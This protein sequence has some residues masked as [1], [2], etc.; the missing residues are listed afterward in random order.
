MKATIVVASGLA[1]MLAACMAVAQ[2]PVLGN[3][4]SPYPALQS[5]VQ[6][7]GNVYG[8]GVVTY[9]SANTPLVLSGSNLGSSGIVEFVSYHNEGGGEIVGSAI[10]ATIS[11]WSSNMIF[12]T[13]PNGATSGLVKVLVEGKTSNG[14]PF[15]V[16]PGSYSASCPSFPPSAQLQIT[17]SALHSGTVGQPYSATLS[18]SGGSGA[19]N[20]TIVS[21][22]LPNGLALNSGTGTISGTPTG[23]AGPTDLQVQVTDGESPAQTNVA[24][25][26]LTIQSQILNQGSIYNYSAFYDGVGNV[27]SL[28]DSVIGNW[29]FT[30]DSL[31]RIASGSV[32]L[33]D[34]SGRY[35]YMCWSYDAFGN[36]TQQEM[37]SLGF[38][39]GSGGG[40]AC[41][42][43]STAPVATDIASYDGNNRVSGTNAHG[44]TATPS[45]DSA[46]N[47]L[48]DGAESYL[49]D[50]EGRVCA[51][52]GAPIFGETVMTGYIYDAEGRRVAKGSIQSMSCDPSSNGFSLTESYVLSGNGDELTM[53]NGSGTWQRTN[54]Y[55]AGALI[56]T[57]DTNGLHFHLSD[58]L[59][60][61]RVQAS[62][63]GQPE[64]DLQSLPF[65]DQLYAYADQ[66]AP[67]SADDATPLHFTGKERDTESGN[68]YFG[69]RYYA[70]SM[71][72]FLPPDPMG[73]WVADVNDPQS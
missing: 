34:L 35:P 31:N 70:S 3:I 24:V 1:S 38:L 60:T 13:V 2:T 65:G 16:T 59:G 56:A 43:Q 66:Y 19:Y 8:A 42:P 49:Y 28:N 17:T 6:M 69:A 33:G 58:P 41:Q 36:R 29:T 63:G 52:K 37:S 21:G 20:W 53:T 10:P 9:G 30:Y 27:S 55:A 72:R 45:Y 57:Y 26:S 23:A 64:E 62:S 25:L 54:V 14:L 46:G 5:R 18:A 12:A 40:S 48:W 51:V 7:A 71:G 32:T 11:M 67:A 73:P 50:A 47:I 4:E 39:S 61:R 22:T 68:D 15:I 44:V